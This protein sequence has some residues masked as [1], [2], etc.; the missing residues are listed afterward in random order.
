MCYSRREKARVHL[1]QPSVALTIL[2]A[3]PQTSQEDNTRTKAKEKTE[4]IYSKDK[5]TT[6]NIAS[7]CRKR[8]TKGREW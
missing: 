6:A 7:K 2:L 4:T 1:V 3:K 8:K 5:D